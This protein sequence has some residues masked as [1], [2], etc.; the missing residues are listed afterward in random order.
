M[1]FNWQDYIREQLKLADCMLTRGDQI[2]G[3][4]QSRL[5]EIALQRLDDVKRLAPRWR[6]AKPPTPRLG[7]YC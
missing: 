3:S 5:Y 7:K 1:T 4:D 6:R 2:V